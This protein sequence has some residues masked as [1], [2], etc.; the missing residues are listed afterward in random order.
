MNR[1]QRRSF[2]TP[3]DVDT[4]PVMK[5]N[6]TYQL[7]HIGGRVEPGASLSGGDPRREAAAARR[8]GGGVRSAGP[9]QV[10]VR[11]TINRVLNNNMVGIWGNV[12]FVLCPEE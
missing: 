9:A 8:V 1:D 10:R 5:A 3:G 6:H 11:T 12:L 7:S 4:Q 2:H